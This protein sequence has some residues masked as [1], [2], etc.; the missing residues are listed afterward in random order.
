MN[1][2]FTYIKSYF[3]PGVINAYTAT[4]DEQEIISRMA[5]E[6]KDN[7]YWKN[8]YVRNLYTREMK[9]WEGYKH[10]K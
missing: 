3:I 1:K 6:L 5:K 2:L 9:T 4:K 10:K 7:I 8:W